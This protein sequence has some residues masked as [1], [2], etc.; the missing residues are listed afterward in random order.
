MNKTIT[1]T[2]FKHQAQKL[3]DELKIPI[4]F[5]FVEI[6]LWDGPKQV[7]KK[8]NFKVVV[9]PSKGSN[10][11]GTGLSAEDALCNLKIDYNRKIEY[12]DIICK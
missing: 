12:K 11:S 8:I 10:I 1:L 7:D 3:I 5:F 6:D 4:D 2:E 9:Y